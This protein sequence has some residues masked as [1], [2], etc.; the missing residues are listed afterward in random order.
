MKRMAFIFMLISQI[1]CLI[2][3]KSI[4]QK[5]YDLFVEQIIYTSDLKGVNASFDCITEDKATPVDEF[6]RIFSNDNPILLN[7]SIY[8]LNSDNIVGKINL[9]CTYS[10]RICQKFDKSRY[11]MKIYRALKLGEY[12]YVKIILQ[13]RSRGY[14]IYVQYKDILNSTPQIAITGFIK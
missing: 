11:R 10:K 1:N 3:Q 2:G 8:A 9:E 5:C 14:I 13:D 4:E 6:L 7:D 12:Y